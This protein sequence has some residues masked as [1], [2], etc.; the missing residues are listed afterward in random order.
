MA[1]LVQNSSE[2]GARG[3]VAGVAAA[4]LAFALAAV[5]SC[6]SVQIGPLNEPRTAKFVELGSACEVEIRFSDTVYDD[7]RLDLTYYVHPNGDSAVSVERLEDL[8]VTRVNF[9]SPLA[10]GDVVTMAGEDVGPWTLPVEQNLSDA[11]PPQIVDVRFPVDPADATVV[12][13]FDD[14]LSPEAATD[15]NNYA[16]AGTID[17]P[18]SATLDNCGRSVTVVFD[19]LSGAAVLDVDGLRDV[20]GVLMSPRVG[21]PVMRADEETRPEVASTEFAADAESATVLVEFT[22]AVDLVSASSLAN[23]ALQPGDVRPLAVTLVQGGRI[24]ALTFA[25]VDPP[26]T[27]DV[28]NVRDLNNNPMFAL[29]GA[30]VDA[31]PDVT[32]PTVVAASYGERDSGGNVI[33]L[34]TFSEALTE[35]SAAEPLSFALT[36]QESVSTAA[37]LSATVLPG[38]SQVN[39]AFPFVPPGATLTVAGVVDLNGNS[40]Q[41][42]AGIP[43][44]TVSDKVAPRVRQ[45]M[46]MP[47]ALTP[48]IDVTYDKP[49]DAASATTLSAYALSGGTRIVSAEMLADGRT[50]RLVA[51]AMDREETL[52]VANVI[53]TSGNMVTAVAALAIS[54]ADDE[55]KPEVTSRVFMSDGAE[56]AV[57][58]TFSE[59][60]DKSAAETVGNYVETG[61]N[62]T[63][64]L[65]ILGSDGRTAVVR[66][67]ALAGD[68]ELRVSGVTDLSGNVMV[69]STGPVSIADDST[70][71]AIESVRFVSN[72]TTPS[73]DVV[74]TEAVDRTLAESEGLYLVGDEGVPPTTATLQGDGRTVRLSFPPIAFGDHLDV[75]AVT[76]LS[77][78]ELTPVT[79]RVISAARDTDRPFVIA[80]S[81][82]ANAASPTIRVTFNEAVDEDTAETLDNYRTT[83]G[84]EEPTLAVVQ[85]DTRTIQLTMPSMSRSDTLTIEDVRDFAQNRVDAT[86]SVVIARD[87]EITPPTI[88]SATVISESKIRVVFSEAVDATTASEPSHYGGYPGVITTL[89]VAPQSDGRTVVITI[90]GGVIAAGNEFDVSGVTD[91]NGNVMVAVTDV[92]LD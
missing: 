42:I 65:V 52:A 63:A 19:Q 13:T 37:A 9:A 34:V 10:A 7:E 66:F 51:E 4:G 76:D 40:S 15:T 44:E 31:G 88:T 62:S 47:G 45:A 46:F 17:H 73:V 5:V 69:T 80:A 18:V 64:T 90:Q 82:V 68:A 41:I 83:G 54:G 2:S 21:A 43:I 86:A 49:V 85:S 74:F 30:A 75:R 35:T 77:G 39:V 28:A 3:V 33:V 27:L 61:A 55:T 11:A 50:V 58:V 20:N 38:A 1:G 78:N 79:D 48:T 59:A 53:D 56:P 32:P 67:A 91:M 36:S 12:L 26:V 87:P 29:T 6:D 16:L 92:E 14:A 71:P 81:F 24:A 57:E 25:A 70:P 72:A 60:V 23:Y 84:D 89:S 8:H 22:E